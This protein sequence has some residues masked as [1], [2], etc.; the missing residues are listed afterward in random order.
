MR[1]A[2]RAPRRTLAPW[3]AILFGVLA[4]P[5]AWA[6]VSPQ[7]TSEIS[8]DEDD[9]CPDHG[10]F[11]FA[12][13]LP[14]CGCDEGLGRCD[15]NPRDCDTQADCFGQE[16]CSTEGRCV[17]PRGSR[18]GALCNTDAECKPW[19]RCL[20]GACDAIE[21]AIDADC[22]EGLVCDDTRCRTPQCDDDRDCRIGQLCR[23]NPAAPGAGRRCVAVQCAS[24]DDCG[25]TAV[26]RDGAC[27]AVECRSTDQCRG[28]ELCEVGNRCVTRCEADERCASIV[29]IDPGGIRPFTIV[30]RCVDASS[31]ACESDVDCRRGQRCLG[32]LC[33][34]A[35]EIQRDLDHFFELPPD[36]D[37]KPTPKPRPTPSG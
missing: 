12:N 9:D 37:P 23:E 5:A 31:R 28:C 35:P 21:C 18:R 36:L 11:C 25:A 27:S 24:D 22:D 29:A 7:V 4:H 34:R 13:F 2:V 15:A 6:Q 16:V 17:E 30:S 10:G 3:L 33:L 19:L 14:G 32:G 1:V 26:C 20:G 8:C